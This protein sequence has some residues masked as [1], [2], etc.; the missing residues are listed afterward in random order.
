MLVAFFLSFFLVA[1][2]CLDHN[3]EQEYLTN[4]VF[5]IDDDDTFSVKHIAS[6]RFHRNHKLMSDVFSDTVVRDVRTGQFSKHNAPIETSVR[7]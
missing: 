2:N 1:G 6:A 7:V 4:S 5:L 3:F